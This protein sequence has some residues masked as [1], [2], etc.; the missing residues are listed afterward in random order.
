MTRRTGLLALV[1][2]ALACVSLQAGAETTARL[3]A[4]VVIASP[5]VAQAI[6]LEHGEG[7]AKD[8]IKAAALYCTAA[9]DGD[10]EGFFGLAWMYAN[11][12]GVSRD[13]ATA[14]A[15]FAVAAERGHVHS[16]RLLALFGDARGTLPEC[17]TPPAPVIA[18]TTLPVAAP[19]GAATEPAR[20]DPF[21]SLSG[22]KKKI[23]DLV[24]KV[25][26]RFAVEPELAL[27]VI[28]TESNF[29]PDARSPKDARGLMQ[30]IPATAARFNVRNS[31]DIQ[32]NM[33]GGLT[34]LRWLLAYYQGEVALVAAAYNAGEGTVDRYGGVPP[35]PETRDYVQRVL[36]LFQRAWHPYDPAV[37]DP[38]KAFEGT[39][40]A[41]PAPARTAVKGT[42]QPLRA[43]TADAAPPRTLR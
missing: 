42:L 4:D 32:E 41:R 5:L 38:S 35:Y 36:Q 21:A 20:V 14:G 10:V 37:T 12:R 40:R 34:Y 3:S 11:G 24:K 17:L 6:A 13:D 27:A 23:A 16:Q 31:F 28:A 18:G 7:V 22:R 33:R 1:S 30:L 2:A 43:K 26:P 39:A 19:Q 8:P 25:A 15:L 9:R 29:E